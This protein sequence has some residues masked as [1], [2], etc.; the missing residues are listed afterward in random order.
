V[1]Q[2]LKE[3]NDVCD[4]DIYNTQIVHE[5]SNATI[6]HWKWIRQRSWLL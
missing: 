2:Q 1:T 3:V 6:Q 5:Y 4:N